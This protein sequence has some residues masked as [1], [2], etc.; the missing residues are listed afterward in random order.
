MI[1]NG[2]LAGMLLCVLICFGIPIGGFVILNKRE[3]KMTKAFL[4]GAATFFIFQIVLRIPILSYVLPNQTWYIILS[5]H[6]VAYSLFLGITAALFEEIGRFIVIKYA[7]KRWRE[8]DGIAFGL[9]HGGIE[10]IL[11]VGINYF[12]FLI[13]TLLLRFGSSDLVKQVFGDLLSA[14]L[15]TIINT[16]SSAT[17]L[18][19]G[20]ERFLTMIIHIGM[21]MLVFHGLKKGKAVLYLLIAILVH[22]I[23]DS[24]VGILPLLGIGMAGIELFIFVIASILLVYTVVSVKH[25][26]DEQTI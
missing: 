17:I 7:L 21:T 4:L 19:A 15:V 12:L 18:V 14:Q 9:G 24:A 1:T 26:K 20:L 25:N 3:H 16:T 6:K 11:L 23:L 2:G 22:T 10:A 5:S 13:S 8:S